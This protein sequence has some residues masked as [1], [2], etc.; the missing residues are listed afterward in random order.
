MRP[1]RITITGAAT[2][3][4]VPM[5]L[6]Q[7]PFNVSLLCKKSSGATV[8]YTVQYTGDDVFASDFDASTAKWFNHADLTNKTADATGTLVNPV[9]AV[10]LVVTTSNGTVTIEIIQSGAI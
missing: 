2:S 1:I 8:D 7:C 4:P 10:R 9:T 5:D 6:Y 3:A